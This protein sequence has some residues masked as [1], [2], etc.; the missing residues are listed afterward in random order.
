[1]RLSKAF[2]AAGQ[3]TADLIAS[4]E[5]AADEWL[6]IKQGQ[7]DSELRA[8]TWKNESPVGFAVECLSPAVMMRP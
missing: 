8:E 3:W 2:K 1:M 6:G 5:T 4:C 7:T